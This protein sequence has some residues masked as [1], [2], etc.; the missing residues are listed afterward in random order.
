MGE[1]EDQVADVMARADAEHRIEALLAFLR[2]HPTASLVAVVY[3]S[4]DDNPEGPVY[5]VFFDC[6]HATA[7]GMLT[8]AATDLAHTLLFGS[9]DDE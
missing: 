3:E 7:V 6:D 2:D 4:E 9:E 5:E 8:T 1:L